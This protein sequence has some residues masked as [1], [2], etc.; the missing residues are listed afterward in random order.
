MQNQKLTSDIQ[1]YVTE[2]YDQNQTPD[3]VYHNL[4]HTRRVVKRTIEIAS[5]YELDSKNLF[6]VTAAAW[7]HDCGHLFGCAENHE[8]RSV[9]M[10]RNY[11]EDKD[12][13]ENT[14]QAIEHCIR[15][16]ELPNK[17]ESLL[18]E[19][20]C[21]ADSYHFATEEFLQTNKMVKREFELRNHVYPSNWNDETLSLLEQH[22]FFTGYCKNLLEEG[23]IKNIEIVRKFINDRSVNK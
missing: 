8:D 15:S 6:I 12:T 23:K 10:M 14:I 3:L 9:K 19:I 22:V 16:T 11:F 17:P 13:E 2:L 1:A 4:A 20:L 5:H 18:E 21:D 7:F